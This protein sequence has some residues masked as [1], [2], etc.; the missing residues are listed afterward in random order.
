VT[1]MEGDKLPGGSRGTTVGMFLHN[2]AAPGLT[3]NSKPAVP[4][5]AAETSHSSFTMT[6]SDLL[7]SA[8]VAI[9]ASTWGEQLR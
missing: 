1:R 8:P 3:V 6:L 7:P 9:Q 2:T 5:S 4:D